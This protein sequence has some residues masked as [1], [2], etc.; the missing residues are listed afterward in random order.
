MPENDQS[1]QGAA[2]AEQATKE[3]SGGEMAITRGYKKVRA[4]GQEL[5]G[6]MVESTT[7]FGHF[8][9]KAL[10]YEISPTEE[11]GLFKTPF[12][13]AGNMVDATALNVGRRA[14]E[15]VEPTVSGLRALY[16][17]TLGIV[18][19]PIT[20]ILHPI[21]TLKN[22]VRIVTSA[23]TI[24]KNALKAPFAMADDLI[25]RGITRPLEHLNYKIAKIPVLG[26]L[27]A[28]PTNF[29]AKIA[30]TISGAVR[31]AMDWVTSPVDYVH[32]AVAPA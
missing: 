8:A 3:S 20:S 30:S 26:N 6:K 23:L 15:I 1:E 10:R 17:S 14:L 12:H 2:R 18:F 31:S 21:E 27:I 32:N 28:A 16:R 13:M 7:G 5:T 4:K 29:V 9:R 19:N 11:Q 22:P 24:A 25:D